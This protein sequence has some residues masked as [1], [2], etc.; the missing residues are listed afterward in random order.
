MD[1]KLNVAL[2]TFVLAAVP[3][4]AGPFNNYRVRRHWGWTQYGDICCKTIQ[5]TAASNNAKLMW[6]GLEL[7]V[8]ATAPHTEETDHE[9]ILLIDSNGSG[10]KIG[11]DLFNKQQNTPTKRTLLMW[12]KSTREFSVLK[13]SPSN[14]RKVTEYSALTVVGQGSLR[15][16]F[17][18]GGLDTTELTRLVAN[19]SDTGSPL[20]FTSK[21]IQKI[22]FISYDK[23]DEV[24]LEFIG[25][26][27]DSGLQPLTV[28]IKQLQLGESGNL[29]S[30][31][32]I[33][34]DL[35]NQNEIYAE[36]TMRSKQ[37]YIV[38]LLDDILRTTNSRVF[39]S[40]NR[41]CTDLDYN[42]FL[43][44]YERETNNL[45]DVDTNSQRV[46]LFS[47]RN[48]VTVDRLRT[49][50]NPTGLKSIIEHLI[51]SSNNARR[52]AIRT[53]RSKVQD[54]KERDM[55][56]DLLNFPVHSAWEKIVKDNKYLGFKDQIVQNMKAISSEYI[57]FGNIVI[58]IELEAFYAEPYGQTDDTIIQMNFPDLRYEVIGSHMKQNGLFVQ[59]VE[60]WLQGS[61]DNIKG[62]NAYDAM[63]V[64]ATHISEVVRNPSMFLINFILRQPEPHNNQYKSFTSFYK[65]QP[66][67]GGGTWSDIHTNIGCMFQP[68]DEVSCN[69]YDI[70]SPSLLRFKPLKCP[71][72]SITN[73]HFLKENP[74]GSETTDNNVKD[75]LVNCLA[76]KINNAISK[77]RSF[78]SVVLNTT[79]K[80]LN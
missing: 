51:H 10:S 40:A 28:S 17:K 5:N 72:Y 76:E 79:K 16:E 54:K 38:I 71:Q 63:A 39:P 15:L 1:R 14:D 43:D 65:T 31:H 46:F 50:R 9:I 36:F 4:F 21:S 45:N 69:T 13:V 7:N 35:I 48:A 18:L 25:R 57:L 26:L 73:V 44:K 30:Q 58:S 59:N 3:V 8:C 70:L 47:N 55:L 37:S 41:Y 52:E 11:E 2:L 22:R 23:D 33:E 56:D 74:T 67:A 19:L 61:N 32:S 34:K 42:R 53:E 75:N 6:Q 60:T 78:Y 77:H 29:R 12:N 20:Q 66:M 68:T 27:Q 80:Q 64:T 24:C 62:V 49:I